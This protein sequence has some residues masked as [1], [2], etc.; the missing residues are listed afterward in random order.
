MTSSIYFAA[1]LFTQAEIVFNQS[2]ANQLGKDFK[3]FRRFIPFTYG[4]DYT[5]ITNF[6]IFNLQVLNLQVP[7]QVSSC[8]D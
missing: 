8:Q 7:I 2:L 1:P 6:K 4:A 5:Q 3:A